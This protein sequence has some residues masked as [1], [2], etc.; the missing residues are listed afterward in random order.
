VSTGA[1]ASLSVL[2]RRAEFLAVARQGKKWS[3]SSLIVQCA[4]RSSQ[5]TIRFGL[6]AS[7]KVGKAVIRNRARRRLRALAMEILPHQ[8][9]PGYD[10]VLIARTAAANCAFADLRNEFLTALRKLGVWRESSD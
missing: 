3:A 10:Y 6:T 9:K 4:P 1:K 7:G 2:R 8:S 5:A